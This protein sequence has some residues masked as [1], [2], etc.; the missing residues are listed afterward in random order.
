MV[1]VHVGLRAAQAI[2]AQDNNMTMLDSDLQ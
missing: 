2:M 1:Q